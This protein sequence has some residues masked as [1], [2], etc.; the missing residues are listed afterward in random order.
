MPFWPDWRAC[1]G[2]EN[3]KKRERDESRAIKIA[4]TLGHK[5]AVHKEVVKAVM[6]DEFPISNLNSSDRRNRVVYGVGGRNIN[7]VDRRT[8]KD[9]LND[10]TLPLEGARIERRTLRIPALLKL[11][12]EFKAC[13]FGGGKKGT[14]SLFNYPCLGML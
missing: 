5:T 11:E 12:P 3:N 9:P 4:I 14:F 7:K 8:G 10:G 2:P 6:L 13:L 1:G